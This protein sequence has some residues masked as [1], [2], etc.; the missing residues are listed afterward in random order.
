[1]NPFAI[2]SA[3]ILLATSTPAIAQSPAQFPLRLSDT[4]RYLVDAAGAMRE[5]KGLS[6]AEPL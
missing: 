3:L 5:K 1:M 6:L 2:L 4:G